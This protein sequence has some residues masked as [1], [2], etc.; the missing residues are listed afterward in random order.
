MRR[1]NISSLKRQL[2]QYLDY[3]RGGG[4][5]RI[6]DRDTPV[7]EIVPLGRRKE[8]AD[9]AIEAII[10]RKIREG[11][12]RPPLRKPVLPKKLIKVGGSVVEALLEERRKGR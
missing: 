6:F 2:S 5:V 9:D 4:V 10:E 3:V 8:S 11:S 12:I 7:A 1:T